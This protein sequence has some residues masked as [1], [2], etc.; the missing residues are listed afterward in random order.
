MELVFTKAWLGEDVN[1]LLKSLSEEMK[2]QISGTSYTEEYIEIL[3]E[4]NVEYEDSGME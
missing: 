1:Q 4:D 2:T 3:E